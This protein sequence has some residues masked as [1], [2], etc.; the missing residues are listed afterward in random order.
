MGFEVPTLVQAQAIPAILSRRH[1]YPFEA[2]LFFTFGY[3][4]NCFFLSE[5]CCV[6]NKIYDKKLI[7]YCRKMHTKWGCLGIDSSSLSHGNT[8]NGASTF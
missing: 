2:F 1:V 4:D 8:L 6:I 3:G 7:L 5:S